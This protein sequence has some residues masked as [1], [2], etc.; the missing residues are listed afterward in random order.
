MSYPLFTLVGMEL[1]AAHG[2]LDDGLSFDATVASHDQLQAAVAAVRRLM[3]VLQARA[4]VLACEMR[5]VSPD[6]TS[7]VAA[8]ARTSARDADRAARRADTAAKVPELAE[9]F[10]A[11]TVSGEHVD[12]LGNAL[13]AT[14]NTVALRLTG[15]GV[16]LRRLAERTTPERFAKAIREEI[17]RIET[18]ADEAERVARRKAAVRLRSWLDEFGMGRWAATFDPDT[19]HQLETILDTQTEVLFHDAVPEHCPSDPID[20]QAFLRAHALISLLTGGG[21][22]MG[23][24]EAILVVDYRDRTEPFIDHGTPG[25]DLSTVRTHDLLARAV[26]FT[27]TVRDGEV[28]TAPGP[29]NLGRSTRLANAAQRRV[30]RALY[31]RCAIPGCET[32]YNRL[33]IHHVVWWRHGGATDLDNLIPVCQKHHTL[34]HQRGWELKLAPGRVLTITRPDGT[35][36]TTGPPKR[37]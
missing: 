13:G 31:P 20:K 24:P 23:R 29:L 9:A 6:P 33:K 12:A 22:R 17:H 28:I 16:W 19:Y 37:E 3:S 15:D 2:L 5:R 27:I 35:T 25:L 34:I 36:M 26:T 1:S 18:A 8:A 30:L 10:T 32:R 21:V 7:D 14:S 4:A 11:G